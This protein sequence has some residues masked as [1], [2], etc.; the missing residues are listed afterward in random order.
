MLQT[1]RA[2]QNLIRN[3]IKYG[4]TPPWVSIT[5]QRGM[6]TGEVAICVRDNGLGI[7]AEDLPHI[8]EPFYRS[9]EVVAAQFPSRA[10]ALVAQ[11]PELLSI[12]WVD[13]RRH[14]LAIET[15]PSV[16]PEPRWMEGGQLRADEAENGF[17]LARDLRQPVYVLPPVSKNTEPTLELHVPITPRGQFTGELLVEYS[18]DGLLRYGVPSEVLVTTISSPALLRLPLNGP[19]TGPGAVG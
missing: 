9:R 15:R 3:A 10:E 2:L 13:V 16:Q 1:A 19:S 4:G 17:G 11:Y 6:Y 7:A 12:G 14:V 8:F 5:A 18:V